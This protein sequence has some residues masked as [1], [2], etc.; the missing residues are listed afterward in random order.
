ML[1]HTKILNP[2]KIFV[3]IITQLVYHGV[4][5]TDK[6][7]HVSFTIP[8]GNL[9]DKSIMI[10]D[11]KE[12]DPMSIY[13]DRSSIMEVANITNPHMAKL[14]VAHNRPRGM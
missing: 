14:H 11:Q 6:G 3:I 2:F 4:Y 5:T 13:L 7:L 10:P 12:N 9:T 8:S 1:L